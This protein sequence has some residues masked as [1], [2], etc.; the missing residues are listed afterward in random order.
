M[1]SVKI[2]KGWCCQ[3]GK[4][5]KKLKLNPDKSEVMLAGKDESICPRWSNLGFL[6]QVK[7][8]GMLMA[9]ALLFENQFGMM[10]VSLFSSSVQSVDYDL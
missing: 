8:L 6:E 2:F 10:A 9:P 7:S 4:A 1:I 5:E 3:S